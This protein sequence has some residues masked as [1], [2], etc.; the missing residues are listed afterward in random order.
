MVLFPRQMGEM[1]YSNNNDDFHAFQ[2]G[3]GACDDSLLHIGGIFGTGLQEW[4][5]NLVSKSLHI[6]GSLI[7]AQ[8]PVAMAVPETHKS[9]AET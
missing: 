8:C 9:D 6:C 2:H 3:P 7:S 1:A 5:A 4:D